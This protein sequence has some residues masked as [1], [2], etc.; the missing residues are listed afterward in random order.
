MLQ[1]GARPDKLY[2]LFTVTVLISGSEKNT[3]DE[4]RKNALMQF[5][6]GYSVFRFSIQFPSLIAL[7]LIQSLP[8]AQWGP[9]TTDLRVWELS[10]KV[11]QESFSKAVR[12]TASHFLQTR[13]WQNG[14]KS[15]LRERTLHRGKPARPNRQEKHSTSVKVASTCNVSLY[16]SELNKHSLML[17]VNNKKYSVWHQV[18]SHF[19]FKSINY[20][21]CPQQVFTSSVC[22]FL[23]SKQD[24]L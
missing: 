24:H 7:L 20:L 19:A 22:N 16:S 17:W 15:C 1:K 14:P 9:D 8:Y 4:Q 12:V 21:M 2:T 13:G 5:M 11:I 23:M 18:K 3:W 6:R 10:V